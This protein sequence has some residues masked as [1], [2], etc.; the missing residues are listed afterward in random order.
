MNNSQLPTYTCIYAHYNLNGKLEKYVITFLKALAQSGC[1]IIFVSDSPL[2]TA[3]HQL[4]ISGVPDISLH[5]RESKQHGLGAWQWAIENISL[6]ENNTYVILA[7]DSILGPVTD[8]APVMQQIN[9]SHADFWEIDP[10]FLVLSKGVIESKI[11]RQATGEQELSTVL[12]NNGYTADAIEGSPFIKKDFILYNGQNNENGGANL[13]S[14]IDKTPGYDVENILELVESACS[15]GHTVNINDRLAVICQLYYPHTIF[16]F[17]VKLSTLKAYPNA[18]FYIN[19]STSLYLNKT[20]CTLLKRIFPKAVLIHTPAIGRDIGAKMAAMDVLLKSGLQ[21]DYSL[22]IHDKLS[23]HTPLGSNWRDQL[24][25]IINPDKLPRIFDKFQ[26]DA[27]IGIITAA[28][29]IKNEYD[30]DTETFRCSSSDQLIELIKKF[31]LKL[32]N[33]NYAAGTMFWIRTAILNKFFQ[34]TSPLE[35]RKTLEAGNVLDFSQGT[36]VHAW[37]RAFSLIANNQGYK[38]SGV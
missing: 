14:L 23:P 4:L 20:F 30:A 27:S 2:D 9:T 21:S 7:N 25:E 6:P 3:N 15:P 26:K 13:L 34:S 24:L 28:N 16:P 38:T 1:W 31:N 10:S 36:N 18:Q 12:I 8:L 19:L 29:Y 11:V 5:F 33:Y 35:I 32:T 22:L 17:L 37:E